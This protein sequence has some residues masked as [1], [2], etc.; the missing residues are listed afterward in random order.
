MHT[1]YAFEV[2]SC[3][4]ESARL[5]GSRPVPNI[6]TEIPGPEGACARRVRRA[7]TSPSLPRAYPLVPVRGDGLPSRTSTATGSW[8]SRRASR[9][10]P[11]AMRIRTSSRP[12]RQQ[13]AR[14]ASTTARR[15][16]TC[17]S[18]PRPARSSPA[19]PRSTGRVRV[20]LG[21][22]G[23]EVVEAAIKLARYATQSA[24]PRRVPGRVP[25]PDV[26]RGQPDGVQGQVPRR[27]RAAAAGRLPRARTAGSRTCAGST[28]C[29]SSGWCPPNEVAAIIVE[30]IQGEGGYVVPEPGF[31]AGPARDLRRARHPADRRRDPV[32]RRAAPAGC[33]RSS[34][35]ASSRTSC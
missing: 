15:T 29:C 3:A 6:V 12:S 10:T 27:L 34:T 26:R 30:P 9:S 18:T 7:W 28:R 16:S 25:R 19:S 1:S 32:G 35:R 4:S 23:A 2:L 20:Y 33:G 11:R 8:T 17:P 24:V 14:A 13:A 22:S 21:N 5:A 31:L